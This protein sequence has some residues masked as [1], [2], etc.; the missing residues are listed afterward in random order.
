MSAGK[1]LQ[2]QLGLP[3]GSP[4][5]IVRAFA[6]S[7]PLAA[8]PERVLDEVASALRRCGSASISQTPG[9]V[10]F[11]GADWFTPA[12]YGERRLSPLIVGGTVTFD[13]QGGIRLELW[14]SAAWFLAALGLA[15]I[16]CVAA[17]PAWLRIT[18]LL[19][20]ASGAWL[21]YV[22]AHQ[23]YEALV[24]EAARRAERP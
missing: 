10:Q 4:I 22:H 21:L 16:L 15:A 3:D 9:R 8:A 12:T 1:S 13:A 20:L 7:P 2:A 14:M 18:G 17:I 23:S 6:F 19:S 5:R 11:A 24:A